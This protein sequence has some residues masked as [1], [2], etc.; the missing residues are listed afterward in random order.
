MSSALPNWISRRL[1]LIKKSGKFNAAGEREFDTEAL[2]IPEVAKA[3]SLVKHVD[4]S[5][6]AVDSLEG[7]P[8][9]P[10]VSSFAA[11][12]TQIASLRNFG[13][14]QTAAALSFKGTPLAELPTY[15]IG[16]L[17]ATGGKCL[18]SI[19]G[20][21]VPAR[22]RKQAKTYPSFCG[23]LVNRGWIPEFPCPDGTVL[24][25]ICEQYEVEPEFPTF[26][27]YKFDASA[28]PEVDKFDFEELVKKLK[29]EHEEVMMRGQALFGIVNREGEFADKVADVL[30]TGGVD[31]QD[32]TD[33]GIVE[34][35][36]QL[37]AN[38]EPKNV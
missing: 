34:T 26:V 23:E 37:C 11:D 31:V 22:V 24:L 17:L 38:A 25:K 10:H 27:P 21:V 33:E 12:N 14:L 20:K 1:P 6:T 5:R 15:Q 29:E 32:T 19:D 28:P 4:V 13:I 8:N 2:S 16:L 7:F 18:S 9:L 3:L 35:V 36:R 30:R